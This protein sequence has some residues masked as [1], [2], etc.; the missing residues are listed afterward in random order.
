MVV[1]TLILGKYTKV[2]RV[3]VRGERVLWVLFARDILLF[4]IFDFKVFVVFL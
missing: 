3:L 1:L 2:H 4:Y